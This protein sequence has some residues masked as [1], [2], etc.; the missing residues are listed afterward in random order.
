MG[1]WVAT[2]PLGVFLG[3]LALPAAI[4]GI[5]LYASL[6]AARLARTIARMPTTPLG[7]AA[8]GYVELEGTIEALPDRVLTARLTGAPVA[9]SRSKVEE[10]VSSARSDSQ[11][12]TW[13]TL[14]EHTSD[15]P[16]VLRD[17]S[18]A[19]VILPAGAEVTPTDRSVW[20][21]S[22]PVPTD[23]NPPRV[24]PGESP[25][26]LLRV[27]STRAHRYRYTEERIYVGDPLYALGELAPPV[28][29]EDADEER[30]A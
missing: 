6:R 11:S 19:C 15:E 1:E 26:G 4:L 30:D 13:R 21:G 27:A 29:D 24:G 2:A 16:F 7:A 20:Y 9:W 5:G 14:T 8:P 12:S 17:A 28:E 23:R 22:T 3:M 10:Y 18:G 25:E